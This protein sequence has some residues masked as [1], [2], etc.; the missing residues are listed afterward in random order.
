MDFPRPAC[1]HAAVRVSPAL[2]ASAGRVGDA[3][4]A[5]ITTAAST[6]AANEDGQLVGSL[7]VDAPDAEIDDRVFV[8]TRW[9]VDRASGEPPFELNAFNGLS[10]PHTERLLLIAGEPVR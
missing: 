4:V 3:C 6:P 1:R 8:L 5:I 10:W 7:I 9:R 2:A